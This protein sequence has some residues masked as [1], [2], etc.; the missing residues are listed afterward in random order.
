LITTCSVWICVFV[1]L[2]IFST[3]WISSLSFIKV[4]NFCPG[5]RNPKPPLSVSLVCFG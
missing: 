1:L 3:S 4:W 5:P 2:G